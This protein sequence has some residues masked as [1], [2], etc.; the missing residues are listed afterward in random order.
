MKTL[1]SVLAGDAVGMSE[2]AN[3]EGAASIKKVRKKSL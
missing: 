3:D 2:S 1:I